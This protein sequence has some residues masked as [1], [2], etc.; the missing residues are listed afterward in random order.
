MKLTEKQL[1]ELI[2]EETRAVIKE[3]KVKSAAGEKLAD[4]LRVGGRALD[5]DMLYNAGTKIILADNYLNEM[6]TKLSKRA[7]DDAAVTKKLD[8]KR[9]TA[10]ADLARRRGHMSA[11]DATLLRL[12]YNDVLE[13]NAK[14]FKDTGAM[15][16]EVVEQYMFLL[17]IREVKIGD[18]PLGLDIDPKIMNEW[19][20]AVASI[21]KRF[22]RMTADQTIEVAEEANAVDLLDQANWGPFRDKLTKA[23]RGLDDDAT[24]EEIADVINAQRL[25]V[26]LEKGDAPTT[27]AYGAINKFFTSTSGRVL[28]GT[29]LALGIT[30]V[31]FR[32]YAGVGQAVK[33]TAIYKFFMGIEDEEGLPGNAP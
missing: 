29:L 17:K 3:G 13:A 1:E 24:P 5:S 31:S 11:E 26:K 10:Y 12:K 23:F 32:L 4:L 28:K 30:E 16:T 7:G 27:S 19:G 8:L 20:Q 18:R 14:L 15:N 2:L 6:F 22:K 33:G 9:F 25:T 21:A